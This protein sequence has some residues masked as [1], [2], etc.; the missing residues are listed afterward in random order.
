MG[1]TMVI[2]GTD[3]EKM[4]KSNR[5]TIP[6]FASEDDVRQ[7]IQTIVTDSTPAGE[8]IDPETATVC[9]YLKLIMSPE[10]YQETER[11]CQSGSVTYKELKD[12]CADHYL[13]YFADARQRYRRIRE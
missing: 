9:S 5:N 11:Q 6:I 1:E 8:P 7:S 12:Q 4:S 13:Q 10:E 3:G 2:P